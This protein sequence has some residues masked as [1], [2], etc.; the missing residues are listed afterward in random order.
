MR[1]HLTIIFIFAI[2][3]L[4][5]GCSCLNSNFDCPMKPGIYCESID[6]VNARVDAGQFNNCDKLKTT[7]CEP[8]PVVNVSFDEG[9]NTMPI[10]SK[11]KIM[12]IFVAAYVDKDGNFHDEND[13]YTVVSEPHWIV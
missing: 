12:H 3:S 7:E 1:K 4:L 13:I 8:Y 5:T 2:V 11:E 10:R 6:Q 9:N